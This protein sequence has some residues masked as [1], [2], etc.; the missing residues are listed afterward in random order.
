[1]GGLSWPKK[2]PKS[3]FPF[4]PRLTYY[5]WDSKEERFMASRVFEVPLTEKNVKGNGKRSSM[6]EIGLARLKGN[7]PIKSFEK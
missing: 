7:S 5:R 1:M 3:V 6:H 2:E 4:G